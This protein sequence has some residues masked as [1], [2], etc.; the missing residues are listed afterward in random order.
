MFLVV[1]CGV[2]FSEKQSVKR[3]FFLGMFIWILGIGI[4]SAAGFYEKSRNDNERPAIVFSDTAGVKSEPKATAADS[5][6]LHEGTKVFILESIANW[7]K[8]S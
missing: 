3:V 8:W 4:A 2:L 1:F 5:F 7:K 6:V